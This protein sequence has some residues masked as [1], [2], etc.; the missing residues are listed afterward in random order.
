MTIDV[1]SFFLLEINL[2]KR[3]Y[4]YEKMTVRDPITLLLMVVFIVML[5]LI[6]RE[7][8]VRAGYME[9]P[10]LF[11]GGFTNEDIGA[12]GGC[13]GAMGGLDDDY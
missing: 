5:A 4:R 7:L 9:G 3:K 2:R 13:C 1:F 8:V 6:I 11:E 12:I 10:K